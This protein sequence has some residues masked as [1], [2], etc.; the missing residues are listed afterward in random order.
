MTNWQPV[1]TAALIG[2]ERSVVPPPPPGFAS[3]ENPAETDPAGALLDQAALLTAARRAGR[4]PDHAELP[5]AAEED[6]RP[7][8]SRA[9]TRRLA[10]IL[11]GENSD[12]L[13]EWLTAVAVRDLRLP[14]QYLPALLDR[15]RRSASSNPDPEQARLR[16]LLAMAGGSRA[17]WLAGL[18]PAWAYLLA[19]PVPA[20]VQVPEYLPA[21]ALAGL[22]TKALRELTQTPLTTSRLIRTLGRRADPA[23]GA[24][25]AL[26]DFPPEAP[27]TLH[28]MLA[29]LRFRYEMLKEL[30]DDHRRGDG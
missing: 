27:N 12:L 20:H 17:R 9:A 2:T 23:L 24:P 18:N 30:D 5:P 16:A 4:R 13:V 14:P 28:S 8:V 6:P 1:L 3:S 15:A 21:E 7:M 25:G 19:E 29:V 22:L 11:G 26:A 10:R